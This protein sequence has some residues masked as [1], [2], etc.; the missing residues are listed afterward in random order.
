GTIRL[1]MLKS[2]IKVEGLFPSDVEVLLADELKREQ[3]LVNPFVTVAVAEYHS[4]PISINGAVKTPTVFQAIGSVSLLDAIAKGGGLAPE[5]GGEIIITRP[6]GNTGVQSMQR[7][8]VKALYEGSDPQLNVKLTGGEE[9]RVP[10]AG[11]VVVSGN[12]KESGIFPV[13]DT[14]TTTVLTAIAQAKGLG[15]FVPKMAYIYRP[16]DQGTRHEIPVELKAIR[17][18]KLPDVVLQ[19]KDLLYVPDNNGAKARATA[20]QVMTGVG[21]SS[22]SAIIY[23]RGR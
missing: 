7:V 9:I 6:N 18:R 14:G 2:T 11:T 23:T 5:A 3:L 17:A 12:V 15:D 4:R 13:Q 1:P 22:V 19:P 20:I 21:A 10:P 16:D 8:P